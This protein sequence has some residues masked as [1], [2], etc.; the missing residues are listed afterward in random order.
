MKSTTAPSF[1]LGGLVFAPTADLRKELK[2]RGV[3][4]FVG[5]RA[6][7]L[8]VN[9]EG[10]SSPAVVYDYAGALIDQRIPIVDATYY[11]G[12]YHRSPMH[13][14]QEVRVRPERIQSGEVQAFNSDSMVVLSTH[15]V[16]MVSEEAFAKATG[17]GKMSRGAGHRVKK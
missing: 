10:F 14:L 15:G 8:A 3:R 13:P 7:F 1:E 4:V 2:A 16:R 5:L 17:H 9:E 6:F 11:E 12:T